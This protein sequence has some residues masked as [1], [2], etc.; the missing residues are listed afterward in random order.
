MLLRRLRLPPTKS[1]ERDIVVVILERV[2][3][4]EVQRVRD[5][6]AKRIKLSVDE[7][8]ARL[9]LPIRASLVSGDRFL[10]EHRHWLSLQLEK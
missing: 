5:P 8:G 2:G 3:Q 10:Q 6:R 9:T 7:R 1:I 4:I